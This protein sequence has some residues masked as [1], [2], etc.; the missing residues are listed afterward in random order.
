MKTDERMGK[1]I[2]R[3]NVSTREGKKRDR[4]LCESQEKK[5]EAGR[6]S[7]HDEAKDRRRGA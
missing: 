5:T 7:K 4:I 1:E 6:R 2:G 3:G